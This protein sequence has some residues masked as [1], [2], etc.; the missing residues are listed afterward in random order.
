MKLLLGL[1]LA[2]VPAVAGA[3]APAA[4]EAPARDAAWHNAQM[5]G[6]VALRAEDGW[7]ATAS[8]LRYRVVQ[9][10]QAEAP[11]PTAQ[12]TVTIHYVGTFLDGAEFDSSVA[13]GEPATFPLP[14]LIRG[15]QEGVPLMRVGEQVRVRDPVPARLRAA[16]PGADPGRRDPAVHDRIAGDRRRLGRKLITPGSAQALRPSQSITGSAARSRPSTSRAL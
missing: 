3:Q 11:R 15:W 13:R 5:L 14:R 9:P 16:G 6:L 4:E 2:A 1:L 10:A 7:R 12:D 8:G